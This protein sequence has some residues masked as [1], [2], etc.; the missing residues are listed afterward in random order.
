MCPV[1]LINISVLC[2][3]LVKNWYYTFV[4][5]FIKFCLLPERH[6]VLHFYKLKYDW[7]DFIPTNNSSE[8]FQS[9]NFLNR[10]YPAVG[11]RT[12]LIRRSSRIIYIA[13]CA[14][15]LEESTS[16]VV[17]SL[18]DETKTGTNLQ[19]DVS[20][21]CLSLWPRGINNIS[22][23]LLEFL[24]VPHPFPSTLETPRRRDRVTDVHPSRGDPD[25]YAGF[26][27][28]KRMLV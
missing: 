7:T 18:R 21:A 8:K 14:F 20:R 25:G 17:R 2:S 9:L 13:A 16:F 26:D 27:G 15:R 4:T 11:A 3:R 22:R 23:D 12:L 1:K 5:H 10:F 6:K 19:D 28:N 24:L